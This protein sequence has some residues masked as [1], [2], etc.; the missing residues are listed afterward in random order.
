MEKKQLTREEKVGIAIDLIQRKIMKEESGC[1]VP[2]KKT[3]TVSFLERKIS[4]RRLS[5]LAY[6]GATPKD[7]RI[8]ALCGNKNCCNP[9]HL[10]SMPVSEMLKNIAG[11]KDCVDTP[12]QSITERQVEEILELAKKKEMPYPDIGMRYGLTK[13]D[14]S[15]I[16]R[17][18]GVYRRGKRKNV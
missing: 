3:S 6:N 14:I 13:A 2:V 1:W 4:L 18:N 15:E 10:K 8:M 17:N 16:C 7:F 9:E 12:R 11:R 5:Y